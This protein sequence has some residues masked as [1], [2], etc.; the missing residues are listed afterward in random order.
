MGAILDWMDRFATGLQAGGGRMSGAGNA[1]A[2]A[3]AKAKEQEEQEAF[4][5]ALQNVD[6]WNS[7]VQ[8]IGQANPQKGLELALADRKV[9]QENTLTPYQKR[10]LE[11][12]EQKLKLEDGRTTSMKD[13]EYFTGLTPDE[14]EQ[15]LRLKKA[16]GTNI[17]LTPYDKEM[18]KLQAKQDIER[19]QAEKANKQQEA[20]SAPII[21]RGYDVVSDP[22]ASGI[23]PLAGTAL[24]QFFS[25]KEGETNYADIAA[26]KAEINRIIRA[27]LKEAGVSAAEM[28]SA[29]EA[30]SYRYPVGPMY[31][32]EV[33]RRSIENF[34]KAYMPDVA[35]QYGL[36]TEEPLKNE[37][38]TDYSNISD[39]DLLRGL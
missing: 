12:Q 28:N 17:E 25:S 31:K 32:P 20:V 6:D 22:N 8:Q 11:L 19:E 2:G 39:E 34:L 38:K 16:G 30:E 29:V 7:V 26:V 27:K 10:M 36:I 13:Y 18:Q 9:Q 21:M 5:H 35:K 15:Y 1:W 23:G 33:S 37:A 3:R 24:G 4:R 14:Q